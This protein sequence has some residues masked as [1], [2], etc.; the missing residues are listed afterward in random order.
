MSCRKFL[1]AFLGVLVLSMLSS[2][3]FAEHSANGLKI[4]EEI[5][6]GLVGLAEHTLPAVVNISPY[7]PPSP[8]IL[9]QGETPKGR[10][11]N[12]GAGVIIDGRNGYIVTNSHVVKKA[13]KILVTLYKGKELIGRVLGSDEETDLAV[14]KVDSEDPL[15]QVKLGDSSKLKVGQLVVAIGNPYGL[16]DTL[17]MG[18]ISGLNRENINISRYEDFIQTDASINPGNSGGPLLNIRGEIIGINTAIIHYAQSIGF[19]IPSN[20]VRNVSNQIIETGEVQRGWLGVGIDFIPEN[21]AKRDNIDSKEGVLVNSV[22]KDQPAS[23]AGIKIGDIILKIGGIKVNSPGSMIKLIG[24]ISPGQSV[25]I[26]ILRKGEIKTV[27]VKLGKKENPKNQIAAI[28]RNAVTS[29]GAQLAN[30]DPGLVEKFKTQ[31]TIGVI[32]VQVFPESSA[33][34]GG[35]KEGDIIKYINGKKISKKNEVDEILTQLNQ[36]N[37]NVRIERGEESLLLSLAPNK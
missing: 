37:L 21:I 19:S 27:S 2:R 26:D 24:N 12:A 23:N 17:S 20:V 8:S 15:P 3:S 16:H 13:E 7:V 28:Q 25:Q 5:E 35:L 29:L 30:I 32:V 14:I 34:R 33:E 11:T 36:E 1:F 6:I 10:S 31:E 18:V 22:F 4:L 9:K